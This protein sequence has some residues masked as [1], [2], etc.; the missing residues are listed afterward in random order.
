MN[1]ST[2]KE[3]HEHGEQTCGCQGGER[4]GWTGSLGS[5]DANRFRMDKQ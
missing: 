4:V 3:T 2:E 5:V 1:I